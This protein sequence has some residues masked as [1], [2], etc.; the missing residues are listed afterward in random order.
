MNMDLVFEI[1][2]LALWVTKNEFKDDIAVEK[3]L[4]EIIQKGVRVYEDHTGEELDRR[5]RLLLEQQLDG[6]R[7]PG[8][9]GPGAVRR[10]GGTLFHPRQRAPLRDGGQQRQGFYRDRRG[11]ARIYAL[12]GL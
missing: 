4:L 12:H 5:Y 9:L 2:D 6:L 7:R 1:S 11:G 10:H 3:T 8:D